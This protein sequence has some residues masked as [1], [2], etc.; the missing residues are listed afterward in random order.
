MWF[1]IADDFRQTWRL[2]G[3]SP[4]DVI[5]EPVTVS[6]N[7]GYILEMKDN[8]TSIIY[9]NTNTI[10]FNVQFLTECLCYVGVRR[11]SLQQ[12][13]G[14]RGG[15]VTCAPVGG[16]LCCSVITLEWYFHSPTWYWYN[17][18]MKSSIAAE[19]FSSSLLNS[20][21]KTSRANSVK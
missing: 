2:L 8:I 18:E 21:N 17:L 10:N 15:L 5:L 7:G 11:K 14:T 13:W 20:S 16:R 4:P 3:Y 9:S 19:M 1:P 12:G 6:D